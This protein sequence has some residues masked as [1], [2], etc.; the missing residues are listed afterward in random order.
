MCC[1]TAEDA[2]RARQPLA[3]HRTERADLSRHA[4]EEPGR[5][6]IGEK[7]DPNFRHGEQELVAGNTMRAMYGHADASAHDDA[8]EQRHVGLRVLLDHGVER[9]LLA[10]ID[11]CL[12][13]TSAATKLVDL[14]QITTGLYVPRFHSA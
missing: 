3:G 11:Q 5:A 7:S 8:V 14:T 13:L 10:P 4:W 1:D 2:V 9:I 12:I 6:D